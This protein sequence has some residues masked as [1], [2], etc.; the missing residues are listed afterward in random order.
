MHQMSLKCTNCFNFMSLDIL[1]TH[2]M[3]SCFNFAYLDIL[4]KLKMFYF[5]LPAERI[6]ESFFLNTEKAPDSKLEKCYWVFEVIWHLI[7]CSAVSI[8]NGFPFR[9]LHY[10]ILVYLQNS[11]DNPNEVKLWNS[12]YFSSQRMLMSKTFQIEKKTQQ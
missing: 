11:Y 6:A 9:W 3:S 4:I 1:I 5:S 12:I 7:F 10:G 2:Q 8:S